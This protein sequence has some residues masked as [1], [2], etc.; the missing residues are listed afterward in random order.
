VVRQ[1]YG[2]EPRR[3]YMFGLSNGG[4]LTRWQL[5]NEP[6]L[7]DGGLDWEGTLFRAD[8]PNLLTYLPTALK[9]YPAYAATGDR[10]AHDAMIRAGFAPGSEF[11]WPYHH[12]YYWDLTQRIYREELDPGYDGDLDAGVPFCASGTPHCDADYDYASRPQAVKD[13]VRSVQ[14]T[15]KIGK[16]MLTVHGTLDTL[17]PPATDSD[18]YDRLVD[19]AGSG[20]LHRYYRV[21]DGT[22]VD[23]LVTTYPDRLRP[24]LPCARTAFGDLTRWVERGTPPPAD[25]YYPR[26]SGGD[27]LDACRL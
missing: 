21:E 1:R 12:A 10:A 23:S 4:Y 18:V 19:R 9:S 17:L 25:G 15:G 14:L 13:A 11:L 20:R 7:Y 3:T 5:E 22:H 16:P 8:G 24:L 26:P 2:H 27:L 6:S